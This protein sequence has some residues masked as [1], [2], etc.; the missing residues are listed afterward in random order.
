MGSPSQVASRAALSCVSP[1]P[2]AP[3]SAPSPPYPPAPPY[4]ADQSPA[5]LRARHNGALAAPP[6]DACR[7]G[8]AP[9]RSLSPSGS[10]VEIG[11]RRVLLEKVGFCGETDP[12]SRGHPKTGWGRGW[13]RLLLPGAG[14]LERRAE[15]VLGHPRAVAF[16]EAP[17]AHDGWELKTLARCA[18]RPSPLKSHT[19]P[20]ARGFP[21]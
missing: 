14:V 16:P 5:S 20:T 7:E 17:R 1:R 3:H 18:P 6:P 15:R 11:L 13:P 9:P 12:R 4:P 21:W 2:A 10:V 8:P 19:G